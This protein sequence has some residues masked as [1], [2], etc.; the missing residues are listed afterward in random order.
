MRQLLEAYDPSLVPQYLEV[1]DAKQATIQNIEAKLSYP[2]IVKPSGLEGSLLITH[3]QNRQELEVTLKHTFLA[4]QEVYDTWVKR[5]KPAVLVE[6]FMVTAIE[7]DMYTIDVYVDANGECYYTPTI[8]EI[9]GRSVGY[10]DFFGYVE[11][12]PSGLDETEI[13]GSQEAA[14]KAR[15][16][17]GLRSTTAHVELMRT[18]SGWKIIELGPRIGGYR[19]EIYDRAYGINHIVNDIRNRAGEEPDIPTKLQNYVAMFDMY[20]REETL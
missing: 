14:R 3:V 17:L 16:A 5:Q 15:H 12:L 13:K 6:E 2:V 8:G 20:P 1:S 19:Y 4:M 9:V 10:D 7:K 18:V 11:L